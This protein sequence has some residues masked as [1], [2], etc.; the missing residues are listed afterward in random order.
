M[1]SVVLR[2]IIRIQA[3]ELLVVG[4]VMLVVLIISVSPCDIIKDIVG[5]IS[6]LRAPNVVEEDTRIEHQGMFEVLQR[7]DCKRNL[8]FL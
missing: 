6:V 2:D 8:V 5:S 3:Y 7:D 1:S 4:F